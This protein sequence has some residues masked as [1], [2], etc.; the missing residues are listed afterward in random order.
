MNSSLDKL[1]IC[2]YLYEKFIEKFS[3]NESENL[4]FNDSDWEYLK[5]QF[6]DIDPEALNE[7]A[8][9]EYYLEYLFVDRD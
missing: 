2:I 5:K 7:G 8:F 9:W 6:M 4:I 1:A 3:S